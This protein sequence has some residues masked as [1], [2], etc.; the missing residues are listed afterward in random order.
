MAPTQRRTGPNEELT[1]LIEIS[2]ASKKSLA[3]RVNELA[4][5]RGLT[6]NYIHTS[7]SNWTVKGMTPQHPVPLLIAQALAERLGRPVSLAEIGMDESDAADPDIGL[8]LPRDPMDAVGVA[9]HFW[10]HVNRR[11][12]LNTGAFAV[13]AYATPVTR[14]LARPSAPAVRRDEP[15]PGNMFTVSA[16]ARPV[17]KW[18]DSA[19][20]TPAPQTGRGRRVNLRDVEE[21]W[22][23]AEE[24]RRWDAKYGGGNAKNASLTDYLRKRAAPLLRG[25]YTEPIGRELFS[26]SSELSR[27]VGWSNF[28]NGHHTL[29]QRHFIQALNL[30]RAGGNVELGA[31]VLSTMALQT[32]LR[33]YPGEAIDMC[34][35]AYE[36]SKTRAAP[37]VLAFTRLIEARAHARARA[38]RAAARALAASESFLDQADVRSTDEPTWI[39]YL[40]HARL[41]G[42]AAEIHRDLGNP[43]AALTWNTRAASMPESTSTRCVGIRHAVVGT[44]HLQ[45]GDLDQGLCVGQQAVAILSRVE[46]TRARDYVRDVTRALEPWKS[47][48]KVREF[49]HHAHTRLATT[50]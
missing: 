27:L 16:F 22:D 5:H 6:R 42:D 39:G 19:D 30:A 36:R 8:D 37:R 41:S 13:S 31:Y 47:E 25:T 1:R 49:V 3:H 38:P 34:Q 17:N 14:W 21:L 48:K 20:G 10:S 40:T 26:V 45:S 23:A 9:T 29:A 32:L 46:S 2:G 44:A 4:R 24:A 7:V 43:K 33:G 35:G 50:A 15:H 12:F 11:N 28:D 18:L